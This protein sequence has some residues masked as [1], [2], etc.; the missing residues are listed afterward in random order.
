M[1]NM[2][3]CLAPLKPRAKSW[4]SKLVW[5]EYAY[6]SLPVS[7]HYAK[8][9]PCV[10]K[11]DAAWVLTKRQY[12]W[13]RVG[14]IYGPITPPVLFRLPAPSVFLT[15]T[16]CFFPSMHAFFKRYHS[17]WRVTREA[18][19][20]IDDRNKDSADRNHSKPPLYSMCGQKVWLSSQDLLPKVVCQVQVRLAN[21][22]S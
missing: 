18:L 1:V 9:V 8:E 17:T 4:S 13:E 20:R 2:M 15:R 7:K 12:V 11:S 21:R 14:V 5:V 10:L 6:N 3:Y 16:L 19:L 22:G